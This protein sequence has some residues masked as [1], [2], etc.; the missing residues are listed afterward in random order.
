VREAARL[1]ASCFNE[2]PW[3]DGWS[4]ASAANR[5]ETLLGFPGAVGRVATRD[6]QLIGLALG[7]I[8]PWTDGDHFYLAELCV[9]ARCRDLGVGTGLIDDLF[10]A[11]SMRGVVATY[12]LTERESAAA[13]FFL[14]RGFDADEGSAKLWRQ[15]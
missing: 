6:G 7:H 12:L 13:A 4:E 10:A 15:L 9:L 2:P 3:N 14:R 11:L 8:E 5:L 1:Y